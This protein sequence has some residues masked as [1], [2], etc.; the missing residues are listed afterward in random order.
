MIVIFLDVDGVLVHSDSIG[1]GRAS[2]EPG[3]SSF[4]FAAQIDPACVARLFRLCEAT[5][6]K[7][8]LASAWRM[9]EAQVTGLRRALIAAGF[10]RRGTLLGRTGTL[11]GPLDGPARRAAEIQAWL[12]TCSLPGVRPFVLDD[13]YVPGFPQLNDRP[14]Y[15]GGGLQDTH[16]DAA[17][18][19]LRPS[20]PSL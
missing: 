6:A 4:F 10:P 14:S 12:D 7:L 3:G 2:G 15:F 20:P 11:P 1:G 19:L 8:V 5:G 9:H 18:T 13:G 17:L 16:L